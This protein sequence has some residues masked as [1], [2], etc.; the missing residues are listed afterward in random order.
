MIKLGNQ[1]H[2]TPLDELPPPLTS[3]SRT[4]TT[5]P[6]IAHWIN[7]IQYG[8]P[9]F[10]RLVLNR[11]IMRVV[12]ALTRGAPCL[13]DCA[14]TKNYKTSDDIHFHAA[15]QDYSVEE[16]GPRAGFINTGI[17]L[18]DVP[19]GTG[20]SVCPEAINVT[21]NHPITSRFT[22]DR[23]QLST[24]LSTP[25]IVSSLQKHS[26]TAEDAGQNPIRASL[27][28]IGTLITDHTVLSL[29]KAINT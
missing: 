5:S 10:Q 26:I 1:W 3:T 22:M 13:V 2:D 29:L 20:S 28:S 19:P 16:S 21:L 25:V 6:T 15:G 9:V 23:R 24:S 11:E 4:G 14:L 8:D 27:F 18:V 17:S 12:I 7:H